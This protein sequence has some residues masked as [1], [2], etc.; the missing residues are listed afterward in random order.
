MTCM[1]SRIECE[2]EFVYK[3]LVNVMCYILDRYY[4]LIVRNHD[5]E[6]NY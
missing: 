6:L 5:K 4:F 3:M 1:R 2:P